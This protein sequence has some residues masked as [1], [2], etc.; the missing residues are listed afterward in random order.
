MARRA[1]STQGPRLTDLI[2]LGVLTQYIPL[3]KVEEALEATGRQSQRQR[4]L[5]A[6][7]MVYYVLA[8]ALY[9]EVGYGEVLRCLVEGLA[10]LG[11]PV[12]RLRQSARSS[13]SQARQRLGPEPL[14]LLYETL[15][16]PLAQEP[17][18][19]AFYRR[20]RLVSLD[21]STLDLPDTEENEAA[22]GRP[23]A[24]RGQSGFPQLRFVTLV[25]NGTH[26]LFGARV[27]GYRESEAQLARQVLAQLQPAMLCLA[28]RGFFSY[29]MW[30]Q[31]DKT[32]AAL[33]WRVKSNLRLPV[34]QRLNDGSYLSQIYASSR[35]RQRDRG[36]I[37]VRV[38]E[39]R[40]EGIED[41]E[42]LYR[43]VTNL[44][45]EQAAPAAELAALY[46]ERWEIESAFDELKTHLRGRQIVLRSK[47]PELVLQEFY[48]LLLAHFAVRSL[49][50]QAALQGK[51]D[52]DKLSFVHAVR[53][54]K[55]KLPTV[56]AI[57]P[58]AQSRDPRSRARR[59]SG[60]PSQLQPR[61]PQ[62]QGRQAKGQ[63]VSHP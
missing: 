32:G 56:L 38:I 19:G 36:G 4:Q 22:F 27:G 37:W 52:P 17:T 46:H 48:G 33:V 63:Q 41:G 23:G 43:L 39:Y 60:G 59:D 11:L 57:P 12:Q 62:S 25:E 55:R 3:K 7:V 8:L 42:P 30:Q 10:R 51:V 54:I 14:K 1:K 45:D 18:L 6:R 13:I 21:G 2:G 20:W 29:R 16:T 49:M 15:A 61:P 31:G 44:L 53:V 24:S 34:R 35:D 5:P 28:D 9:M 47:T 26:I 50:H 58:S 40:L